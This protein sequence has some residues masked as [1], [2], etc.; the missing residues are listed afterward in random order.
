MT[1]TAPAWLSP[2]ARAVPWQPLA[3]VAVCLLGV[4]ALA[5]IRGAWPV[6]VLDVAAGGTA[7]AVVA[8]LRDPAADLLSA[9]P[10]SAARRR[11]RRLVLLVPAGL[12]MWLA[13]LV[14]GN[15]LSPDLG[16]PLGPAVALIATG[17]AVATWMPDR[18]AVEGGVAVP[19]LWTALARAANGLDDS[20]PAVLSA[21]RDHPWVVTTAAIA[22]LLIGRNR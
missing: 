12:A 14:A 9:V 17:C 6:G 4:V 2:T 5:T 11:V 20:V 22:A 3:G 8:G 19:L 13:Y 21:Y 7:A 1:R 16:W 15:L 10:T 18:L